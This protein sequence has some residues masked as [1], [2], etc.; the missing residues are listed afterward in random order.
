[1]RTP[2]QEA[3]ELRDSM[4][5][6]TKKHIWYCEYMLEICNR[7]NNNLKGYYFKKQ[8]EVAKRKLKSFQI[9]NGC[10]AFLAL[11]LTFCV[12][13]LLLILNLI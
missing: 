5:R 11:H 9:I 7:K 1:M 6:K 8:I 13:A 10:G 3:I 2:K 4:M 12:L